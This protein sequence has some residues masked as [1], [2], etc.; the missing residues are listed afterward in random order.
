MTDEGKTEIGTDELDWGAAQVHDGR[1]PA[2]VI[3][4]RLGPAEASRLRA[5]ADASGLT[6]SQVIRN[7]LAEYE[8]KGEVAASDRKVFV[9]AFTYGGTMPV[10]HEQGWRWTGF[11]QTLLAAPDLMASVGVMHGVAV[12]PTTTE[13]TRVSERVMLDAL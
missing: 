2:V 4:V 6:V 13:P 12:A 9:S 7:A 11:E 10:V 1:Q 3:S 5:S 8:A